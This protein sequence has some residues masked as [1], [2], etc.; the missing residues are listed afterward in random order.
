ML[1]RADSWFSCWPDQHAELDENS[2]VITTCSGHQLAVGDWLVSAG[3]WSPGGPPEGYPEV[4]QDAT[5]QV[6]YSQQT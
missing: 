4:V 3:S 5:F 6:K 1:A 2:Q